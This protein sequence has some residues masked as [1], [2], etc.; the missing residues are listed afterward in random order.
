MINS[1]QNLTTPWSNRAVRAIL[2]GKS[3]ATYIKEFAAAF[4]K[5]NRANYLN[6]D[7]NHPYEIEITEKLA[8]YVSPYNY[9][10]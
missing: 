4:Q 9:F 1:L 8:E 5:S 2:H 6:N 7:S 3:K 10:A